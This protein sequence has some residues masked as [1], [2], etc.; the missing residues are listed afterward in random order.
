M[1][2]LILSVLNEVLLLFLLPMWL[3]LVAEG[4]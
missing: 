3:L 1:A 2:H 4:P